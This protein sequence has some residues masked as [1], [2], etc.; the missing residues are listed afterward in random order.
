M[1]NLYQTLAYTCSKQVTQLYSTSFYSAVGVLDKSLQPSIH[2]IYGFVRLADEIVDSFHQIDKQKQLARFTADTYQAIEE[3]ISL[4]PILHSFQEVMNR[5]NIDLELVRGFFHSMA[6]DLDKQNYDRQSYETYIYGSAEVVGL[7]CLQVFL[8][9]DQAAYERLKPFAM[10]LGSAFQK[11][12]FLRDLG[13]DQDVL[14][15]I[16]F[17][18]MPASGINEALKMQYIAEIQGEFN[19]AK[20]GIDQLPKTCQKGVL[21]AYYYYLALLRKIAKT[22]AEKLKTQRISVPNWKKALLY[23]CV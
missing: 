22:P 6:M 23:F 3:K 15:R 11:V 2:A 21:L 17:P 16:Y 20:Q 19:K 14:G 18:E 10:A 9:G 1:E 7:M 4:N 12:N 5:Y 8:N 13:A